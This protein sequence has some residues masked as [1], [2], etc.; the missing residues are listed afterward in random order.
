MSGDG[1]FTYIKAVTRARKGEKR[2]NLELREDCELEFHLSLIL[3]SN[4]RTVTN[5][6]QAIE[7]I[8]SRFVVVNKALFPEFERRN[9]P[10]LVE[11]A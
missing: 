9:F 5:R 3:T 4:K 2:F 6:R 8:L 7:S 1:S 11:P 10:R